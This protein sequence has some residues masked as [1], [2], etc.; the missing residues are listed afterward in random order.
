M[1][2]PM[3]MKGAE[4]LKKEL[5]YL[6]NIKR[7]EII[8]L[9]SSARKYGDLKENAEYHAA[10]E[11]QTFCE[12]RIKYIE[13]KLSNAEIIDIRKIIHN[14]KVVFGSTILIENIKS[15]IRSRYCIVGEDEADYKKNLISIFSPLARGLIGHKKKEVVTITVPNGIV[16]YKII[17]INYI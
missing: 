6:K 13:K 16:K 4:N 7:S 8:K 1:K 12:K 2:Y 11:E 10:K 3:T 14:G 5:F 17:D 9:I 15:K